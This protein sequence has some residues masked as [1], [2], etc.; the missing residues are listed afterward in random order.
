MK[1]HR[2][3]F[4]SF[5]PTSLGIGAV[6]A[7]GLALGVVYTDAHGC[8]LCRHNIWRDPVTWV[9]LAVLGLASALVAWPIV[10]RLRRDRSPAA[11]SDSWI[12]H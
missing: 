11:E 3:A 4:L 12:H 7:V 5:L 6:V 10:W 8:P 2:R 1:R 9:A